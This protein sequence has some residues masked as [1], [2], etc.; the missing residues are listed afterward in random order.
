MRWNN[1]WLNG[2]VLGVTGCL[3][4]GCASPPSVAPLL[5]VVDAELRRE[6]QRLELD[7]RRDA[8]AVD[9]A[10]RSL[11]DAYD[12]DLA[13][14]EA[15]TA[16]WVRDA[17]DVYVAAREALVRHEMNLRAE[18]EQRAR[19]L[20]AAGEAQRRAIQLIEQHDGLIVGTLGFDL[21]QLHKERSR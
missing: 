1:A 8:E 2:A 6:A 21:W 7:A 12:G 14:R 3:L 18:R 16:E 11:A 17:T 13:R 20:H 5:R 4:V 9:Q 15:L 10:R 19:N